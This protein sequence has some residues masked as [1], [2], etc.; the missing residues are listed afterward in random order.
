VKLL[1]RTA[2]DERVEMNSKFMGSEAEWTSVQRGTLL[3]TGQSTSDSGA[4]VNWKEIVRDW[5]SIWRKYS[6]I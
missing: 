4:I 2:V 3:L 5:E 6:T 1:V